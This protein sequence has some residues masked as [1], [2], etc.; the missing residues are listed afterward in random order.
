MEK[1]KKY[2]IRYSTEICIPAKDEQD[3]LKRWAREDYVVVGH[4]EDH[5]ESIEEATEDIEDV[6]EEDLDD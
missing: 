6:I 2:W 5:L 4:G 1:M 3:A